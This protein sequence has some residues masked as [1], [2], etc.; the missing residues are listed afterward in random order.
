[1][2]RLIPTRFERAYIRLYND[3]ITVQQFAAESGLGDKEEALRVLREYREKI[4][5]GEVEDPR[6]K[7]G[8]WK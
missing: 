5:R 8:K 2:K 4:L 3:K 7:Y 6:G 1:M